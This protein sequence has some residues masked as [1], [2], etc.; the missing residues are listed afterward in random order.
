MIIHHLGDIDQAQDV[1]K[2]LGISN[3]KIISRENPTAIYDVS[4]VIG[5]DYKSLQGSN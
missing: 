2:S 4:V 1:A 3:A 5:K